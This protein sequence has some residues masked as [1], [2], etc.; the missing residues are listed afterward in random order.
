MKEISTQ[1][2]GG[3]GGGGGLSLP[4]HHVAGWSEISPYSLGLFEAGAPHR[5]P[6]PGLGTH[7]CQP[8]H[9]QPSES[10]GHPQHVAWRQRLTAAPKTSSS[11][12]PASSLEGQHSSQGSDPTYNHGAGSSS[13]KG[14]REG[15]CLPQW[16]WTDGGSFKFNSEFW[17][18]QNYN[19]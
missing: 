7:E 10:H 5:G 15:K 11:S 1:P 17:R 3:G 8:G 6:W 19:T 14:V 18:C 13:W 4:W 2:T 16:R 9:P 12:P